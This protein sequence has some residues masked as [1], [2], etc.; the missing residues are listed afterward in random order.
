MRE[1]VYSVYIKKLSA[2]L[3]SIYYIFTRHND[4]ISF[5]G[6]SEIDQLTLDKNK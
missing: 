5:K 4:I 1:R 3:S 2:E 6:I